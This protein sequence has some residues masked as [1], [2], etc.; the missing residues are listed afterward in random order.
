MD[1]GV[2]PTHMCQTLVDKV[3]QSK[4][5]KTVAEPEILVLFEDWLEELEEEIIAEIKQNPAE[6]PL[7]LA[8]RLGLSKSGAT[9]LITK[10]KREERITDT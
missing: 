2:D 1:E 9:F 7:I 10:L 3:F 5:L 6:D 4:Q 8:E